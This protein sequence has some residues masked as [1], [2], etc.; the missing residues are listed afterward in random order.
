MTNM[1]T[2]KNKINVHLIRQIDCGL[3]GYEKFAEKVV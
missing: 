2:N 1:H 3:F